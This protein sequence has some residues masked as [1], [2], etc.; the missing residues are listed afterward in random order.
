[1]RR[2]GSSLWNVLKF[3]GRWLGPFLIMAAL[4]L[5]LFA[6]LPFGDPSATPALAGGI[7]CVVTL[8]VG[9]GHGR[10]R[11]RIFLAACTVFGLAFTGW[12]QWEARRGFHEEIVSFDNRGARIVGTLY[13]P[14]R[15][16]KRPGIVW[17]HG[18][19]P[20][21]RSYE[22]AHAVH[23]A[24]LGFAVLVYDKRGIGDSTGRFEGG[25][26]AIDPANIELLASDASTAM[27]LLTKRP[28]VRGDM[29]GFVGASQAGWITPRAAVLNG[30]AA[31]M[32]L[33]SGPA[34]STHT[35]MQYERFHI[36]K[37]DPT[38]GPSLANVFDA[39]TRGKIPAGMTPDQAD[40]EAQKHPLDLPFAD[41]DPV[42]DLRVLNIPSLWLLGGADWMVPSGPTARIVN[43]L[44][45]A[46]KPYEYRHIPR[47]W[48][49]MAFGPRRLVLDTIDTWL[50]RVAHP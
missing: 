23:F 7:I 12:R 30:H 2:I 8:A 36:G 34:T 47:A 42:A 44:R 33:L 29:V 13:L 20:M 19:G 32:V 16:G 35:Q 25:D 15:P 4:A 37:P 22:S 9:R 31:F 5:F 6:Q 21:P 49:A 18:S 17:I 40:V 26:R 28:E 24:Q 39:F 11:W 38:D 14:E 43:T 41:Y 10:K 3:A 50:I 1:M 45:R 48:H 27:T 46:G